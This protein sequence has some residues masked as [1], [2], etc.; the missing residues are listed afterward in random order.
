[1]RQHKRLLEPQ[2]NQAFS[3]TGSQ[4]NSQK[5]VQ[6]CEPKQNNLH[7]VSVTT[8]APRTPPS[9]TQHRTKY[10]VRRSFPSRGRSPTAERKRSATTPT[11]AGSRGNH[12]TSEVQPHVVT[13]TTAMALHGK[14]LYTLACRRRS[15][16]SP[17]SL[18]SCRTFC[19]VS[20]DF[21]FNFFSFFS[22]FNF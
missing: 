2:E 8:A 17:C 4:H 19:A 15:R 11:T 12:Q 13:R 9:T 1:M 10:P 22:F 18:G 3:K 6:S 16:S 7:G 20:R 14:F 5:I 21:I